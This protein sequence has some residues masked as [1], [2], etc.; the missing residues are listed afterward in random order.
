M[1]TDCYTD[2]HTYMTDT[3][4]NYRWESL[5]IPS[6]VTRFT[7]KVKAAHDVHIALSAAD[8]TRTNFYEIGRSL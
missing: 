5:R 6:D 3:T 8:E 7:F 1:S 4:Y 2:S